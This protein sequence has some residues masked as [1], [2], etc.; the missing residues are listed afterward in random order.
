MGLQVDGV[1]SKD[2]FGVWRVSGTRVTLD[3][4]VYS[5]WEGCSAETIADQFDAVPL[6]D[7]YL[8]LGYYLKNREEV[9]AYLQEQRK[10][11]DEIQAQ[12]E[13]KFPSHGL[14]A[15]LLARQAASA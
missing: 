7:I 14:R 5:F 6:A 9:D 3:S 4:L 1:L 11:A 2:E 13:Q 10:Q 8:A 12:W 15:R